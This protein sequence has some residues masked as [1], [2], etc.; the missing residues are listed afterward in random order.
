MKKLAYLLI[1][2]SLVFVMINIY[3]IDLENF[4]SKSV[5]G[6]ISTVLVIIALLFLIKEFDKQIKSH[7]KNNQN[8]SFIINCF[9]YGVF[10]H[11][12]RKYS[13]Y[14]NNKQIAWWDKNKVRWFNG[15][16]YQIIADFDVDRE[17][18]ISFCLILDNDRSQNRSE[19]AV[20]VDYGN[21]G[22]QAKKFNPDWRP[23]RANHF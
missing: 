4:S 22:P 12:G 9:L 19:N 20:T 15:D 14:K 3:N 21:I 5:S 23:K 7:A 2:V 1:A 18:L 17:L 10:G 13:I 16:N 11:R 8:N 6:S